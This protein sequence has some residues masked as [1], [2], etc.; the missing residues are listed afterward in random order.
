[1][2]MQKLKVK[3]VDKKHKS[4]RSIEAEAFYRIL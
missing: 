2:I 4:V 1:M 3:V